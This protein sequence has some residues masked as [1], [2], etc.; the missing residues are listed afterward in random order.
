MKQ[1]IE[2]VQSIRAAL[3]FLLR[4]ERVTVAAVSPLRVTLRDGTTVPAVAVNG[5]TY[6]VGGAAV[7]LLAERSQP[8]VLPI[9]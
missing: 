7:A 3:R 9:S 1:L 5:L 2:T 4:S 6:T 8:L